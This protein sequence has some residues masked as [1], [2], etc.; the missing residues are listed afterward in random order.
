LSRATDSSIVNILPA[1][2]VAMQDDGPA[3]VMLKLQLAGCQ[4]LLA[5]VTRRSVDGLGLCLG[6]SLYAQVK[7]VALLG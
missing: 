6:Q 3:R 7:A 5:R 1:S 2:L 4:H